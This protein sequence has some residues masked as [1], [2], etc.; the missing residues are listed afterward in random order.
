MS[1]N[2]FSKETEIR[3]LNFFNNKIDPEEMAK[4]IRQI[5]YLL[6]LGIMREHDTFQNGIMNVEN[7]FFWLNEL[8]EVLNPYLEIE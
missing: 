5:N 3:L 1:T 2:T 6:A 8:A 4:V 7:S